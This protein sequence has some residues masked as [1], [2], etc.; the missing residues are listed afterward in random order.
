M[1]LRKTATIFLLIFTI[2]LLGCSNSNNNA[3][4]AMAQKQNVVS[5]PVQSTPP[6]AVTQKTPPTNVSTNTSSPTKVTGEGPNGE[7]IK[8]HTDKKRVMIY[9]LPGD[10]YYSRTTHVSG[11]FFTEKDAQAAGYRHILK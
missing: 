6:P 7:G 3:T 8:G 4:P 11:W 5:E 1:C 2:A 9:H 10:P